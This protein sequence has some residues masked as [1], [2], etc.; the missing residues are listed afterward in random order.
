VSLL[1]LLLLP[2]LLPVYVSHCMT[3]CT[4]ATPRY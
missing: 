4:P 2:L 3:C 1:L